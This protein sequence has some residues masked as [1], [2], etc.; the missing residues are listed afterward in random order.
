MKENYPISICFLNITLTYARIA[1]HSVYS[2]QQMVVTKSV[3]F[4]MI[5]I[6]FVFILLF[7]EY[8]HLVL[9]YSWLI[10]VGL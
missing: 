6:I 5:L 4:H 8:F 1:V 7:Y 10:V 2:Y 3:H 9:P